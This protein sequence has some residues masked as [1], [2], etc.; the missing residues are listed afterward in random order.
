TNNN[1]NTKERSGLTKPTSSSVESRQ[2]K[3][4]KI[5]SSSVKTISQERSL[6]APVKK[7]KPTIN[8]ET[9]TKPISSAAS[10]KIPKISANH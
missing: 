10:M 5:N 8:E 3:P 2:I 7:T 9:I 6:S 1:N 4:P